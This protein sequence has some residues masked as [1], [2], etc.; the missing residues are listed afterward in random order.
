MP[1]FDE[2]NEPH[3]LF[4]L[5]PPYSGST[6]LIQLL[7]S[8]SRTMILEKRGEGQRLLPGLFEPDRWDPGKKV[9]YQSI[10]AVWLN[11]YQHEV[12]SGRKIDV[13]I[14]KSPPNMMRIEKIISTFN[15][16]SL[17]ANNRNPYA[18]CSSNMYRRF[19]AQDMP[20]SKRKEILTD[21]AKKWI[22]RSKKIIELTAKLNL[23]IITYEVFCD[24][25]FLILNKLS[26]PAGVAES[27]DFNVNIKVKDSELQPII[28]QNERQ[29]SNLHISE[30]ETLKKLFL[31]EA[32]VLAFFGYKP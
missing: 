17:L 24:N 4:I 13:V 23:P 12:N 1:E 10:R 29:I 5:T 32:D 28:N 14:E 27:I 20:V 6:A 11:K 21:L 16:Y 31:E 22:I 30:I 19:N 26:I 9:N 3:F 8:G 7:N 2:T 15:N 18:L 25:P